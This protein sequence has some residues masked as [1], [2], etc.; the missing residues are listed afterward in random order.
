MV[1]EGVG[2]AGDELRGKDAENVAAALPGFQAVDLV[3]EDEDHIPGL[4][5]VVRLFDAHLHSALQDQDD[6]AAAVHVHGKGKVGVL[7]DG[8]V[9]G[10][11]AVLAFVKDGDP[12]L[13]FRT[14]LS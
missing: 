14:I 9:I 7:L 2:H 6:L 3:G 13:S 4:D 11:D 8:E 1:G 5:G 10:A 12:L